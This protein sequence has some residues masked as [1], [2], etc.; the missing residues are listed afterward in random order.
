MHKKSVSPSKKYI[1]HLRSLLSSLP[2]LPLSKKHRPQQEIN[3]ERG[4]AEGALPP[5]S[6]YYILEAGGAGGAAAAAAAEVGNGEGG[7]V[8]GYSVWL[9]LVRFW[10]LSIYESISEREGFEYHQSDVS[11]VF[12]FVAFCVVVGR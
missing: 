3:H 10:Y 9:V 7:D 12:A 4:G 6:G 1:W 5:I 8:Y 2:F 11:G